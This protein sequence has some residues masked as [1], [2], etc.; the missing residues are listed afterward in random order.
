VLGAERSV[1]LVNHGTSIATASLRDL[2]AG[3]AL[4]SAYPSGGARFATVNVGAQ[5][6]LVLSVTP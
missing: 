6:V 1:V 2:P 5:S 3:A 4:A